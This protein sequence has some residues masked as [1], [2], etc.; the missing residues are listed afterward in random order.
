M[1]APNVLSLRHFLWLGAAAFQTLMLYKN[2]APFSMRRQIVTP[3][4]ESPNDEVLPSTDARTAQLRSLLTAL[5]AGA[6][7]GQQLTD[8]TVRVTDRA[9]VAATDFKPDKSSAVQLT[10]SRS[11]AHP[12]D[13]SV[14]V[15]FG[16]QLRTAALTGKVALTT[17]QCNAA[18]APTLAR[19]AL[20]HHRIAQ[21][22]CTLVLVIPPIF[23]LLLQRRYPLAHAH[24]VFIANLA[25]LF[26]AATVE[27]GW[28]PR[29]RQQFLARTLGPD[30][31]ATAMQLAELERA[32]NLHQRA[33]LLKAAKGPF[34]NARVA[35]R[36]QAMAYSPKGDYLGDFGLRTTSVLRLLKRAQETTGSA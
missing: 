33:M 15:D 10:L 27:Q 21:L 19:Y 28:L 36:F 4:P 1:S 2:E 30:Y 34:W 14:D 13:D 32:V 35:S 9:D 7:G 11:L 8:F 22:Q 3:V 12:L 23:G 5:M 18:V 31:V 24:S 26:C 16:E 17:A 25:F 20:A 6:G 29:V